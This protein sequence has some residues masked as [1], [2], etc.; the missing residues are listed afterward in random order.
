MTLG[1]FRKATMTLPDATEIFFCVGVVYDGDYILEEEM[2]LKVNT[3]NI[4]EDESIIFLSDEI[5]E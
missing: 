2:E 5:D 1:D 3:L 4:A